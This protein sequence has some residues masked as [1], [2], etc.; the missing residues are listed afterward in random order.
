MVGLWSQTNCKLYYMF[1]FIGTDDMISQNVCSI[2]SLPLFIFAH[3]FSFDN[4]SSY[5]ICFFISLRIFSY[6]ME[7]SLDQPK[8]KY[9]IIFMLYNNGKFLFSC[10]ITMVTFY[11]TIIILGKTWSTLMTHRILVKYVIMKVLFYF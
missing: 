3:L 5:S 11:F 7:R 2:N 6:S 10:Y 9:F 8:F 1:S 4:R